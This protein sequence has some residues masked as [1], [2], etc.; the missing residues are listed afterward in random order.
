MA[1]SDMLGYHYRQSMILREFLEHSY[2]FNAM[3]M[4][5]SEI[6][7]SLKV[8]NPPLKDDFLS[9]LRYCDRVKFAKV[10]PSDD[11]I[12]L[13]TQALRLCLL[14]YGQDSSV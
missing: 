1:Q 7:E 9:I 5:T 11:E 8:L 10:R 2:H 6:Q 12:K 13:Q 4:T 3:E 14:S